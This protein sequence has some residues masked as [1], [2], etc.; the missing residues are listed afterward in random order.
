MYT[1]TGGGATV[2][3]TRDQR[4]ATNGWAALANVQV[5]GSTLQVNVRQ[6]GTGML[7]ADAVRIKYVTN[8]FESYQRELDTYLSS[9]SALHAAGAAA[10]PNALVSQPRTLDLRAARAA[11]A[12]LSDEHRPLS[13]DGM[14]ALTRR[15]QTHQNQMQVRLR[16]HRSEAL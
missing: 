8:F 10:A 5:T 1:L 9:R 7:R 12:M 6:G 4:P 13:E 14:P 11:F 3:A 16:M 2:T 15:L